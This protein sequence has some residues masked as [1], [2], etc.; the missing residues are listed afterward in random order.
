M[1]I[2]D[3]Y[4]HGEHKRNVAHFAAIA[5]LAKADGVITDKE[6]EI[7]DRFARKLGVTAHEFKS[8]MDSDKKYPIDPAISAEKRLER[9]FD[10]FKIVFADHKFDENEIGLVKRY[11]L[12]LGY[13]KDNVDQVVHK[14]IKIFTGMIDFEDFQYLM[15]K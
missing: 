9:I 12:G 15:G 14:A 11:A 13:S 2:V 8:I 4:K 3:A 1:S 5:T 6:S 10:L 7:L